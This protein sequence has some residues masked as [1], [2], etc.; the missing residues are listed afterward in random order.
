MPIHPSLVNTAAHT[1]R[2]LDSLLN[3]PCQGESVAYGM[4]R[5]ARLQG[6]GAVVK[7]THLGVKLRATAE[8]SVDEL[9]AKFERIMYLTRCPARRFETVA[10]QA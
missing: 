4:V 1:Q 2:V 3:M 5:L 7:R 10:M 6:D 9:V 8:S